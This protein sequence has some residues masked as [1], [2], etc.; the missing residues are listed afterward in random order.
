MMTVETSLQNPERLPDEDGYL[1]VSLE[2]E[3]LDPEQKAAHEADTLPMDAPNSA[4][5]KPQENPHRL[6]KF[7][8]EIYDRMGPFLVSKNEAPLEDSPRLDKVRY[9]LLCPPHGQ[10]AKIGTV[11]ILVLTFWGSL[12][13]LLGNVA[14]P[15]NGS[16]FWIILIVVLALLMG[17]LVA[18]IRLP[19]LLGMLLAGII[20]KNIPGV[21]FDE[22]WVSVSSALR[23]LAL[24]VILMRAG[25]GLDPEA[26][27]RLSGM[28]FRL[29]FTPCL[30]ETTVVAVTAHFLL[31]MPWLWG[32]MMGF[33]LAA[34]SP[35]VVVPCLL[36]LQEKGY[37]VAKGIPTLV[38]AAASVDDVLAIS[39][40]TI[41][42]GITF[43]SSE[44]TSTAS[45]VFQVSKRG[46]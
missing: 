5:A 17:R 39:G 3:Q 40:F 7:R 28:V 27:R 46:N 8:T 13:S 24:I 25:L 45:L 36:A 31:K 9:A 29:A 23:G 6:T 12:Y 14:A 11:L 4:T 35:A 16:L 42:L 22:H 41:L 19:P 15:P 33:V 21:E 18:L 30:V 32:F 43:K 2:S 20:V 26:L 10:V 38:I 34:V 44:E 1:D 37:G